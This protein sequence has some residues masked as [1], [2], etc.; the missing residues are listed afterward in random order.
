MALLGLFR[1]RVYWLIPNNNF[2]FRFYDLGPRSGSFRSVATALFDGALPSLKTEKTGSLRS[3][4]GAKKKCNK[5]NVL[6]AW[7]P[8]SRIVGGATV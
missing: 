5:I 3:L 7:V 1:T 4:E 6:E 8:Q 2:F